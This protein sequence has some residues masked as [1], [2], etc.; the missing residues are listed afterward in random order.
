MKVSYK[1]LFKLMIDKKMKKKDLQE[2]TGVS[3]SSIAKLSRDEY[4]SMDILVKI[5]AVFQAQMSDVV[6]IIY[7]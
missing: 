3:A 6:E 1:K 2:L 5:C 7:E 4:V